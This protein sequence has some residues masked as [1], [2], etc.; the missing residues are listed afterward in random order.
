MRILLLDFTSL[1]TESQ[2]QSCLLAK[3]L[4]NTGMD[5]VFMTP[6]KTY[7]AEQ[8][9]SLGV[10]YEK[11]HK[12]IFNY[13]YLKRYIKENGVALI[14]SFDP[15][16]YLLA[17]RLK[18]KI[19]NLVHVHTA[20]GASPIVHDMSRLLWGLLDAYYWKLYKCVELDKAFYSLPDTGLNHLVVTSS[21]YKP[22]VKT[23]NASFIPF[24]E[25][26]VYAEKNQQE[27]H[28]IFLAAGTLEENNGFILLI[29]ALSL[30]PKLFEEANIPTI[31]YEIRILGSGKSFIPILDK[32]TELKVAKY[33]AIFG[34]QKLENFIGSAHV[35]LC[36]SVDADGDILSLYSAWGAQ[37][38][39]ISSDLDIHTELISYEQGSAYI[40][41]AKNT[42]ALAKALFDTMTNKS[43]RE[44]LVEKGTRALKQFTFQRIA[45][46][47][48]SIYNQFLR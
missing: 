29:E 13:F 32:A 6:E 23:A 27:G 5:I 43:L 30:L 22:Q 20:F 2:Q 47:Y 44:N 34:D 25:T 40:Y 39:V 14:H 46:Q 31:S 36:P 17:C 41:S 7:L 37:V 45:D 1:A 28:F 21:R 4:H 42:E 9:Q 19:P 38:P 24:G 18:E 12:S 48:I 15:I 33:L 35:M 16:S 3:A 26:S 11:I 10:P 8:A